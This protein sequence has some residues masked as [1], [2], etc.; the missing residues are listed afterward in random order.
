MKESQV[1]P[2]RRFQEITDSAYPLCRDDVVWM[3][4]V[5]KK[6]VA[7]KDPGF[8]DLSPPRL[9]QNFHGF[10]EAALLLIRRNADYGQE[11]AELKLW[12]KEASLGLWRDNGRDH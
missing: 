2:A 3:L 5:I 9:L 11:A 10:A 1:D 12:L 8:L 6:K 7:E 4:E